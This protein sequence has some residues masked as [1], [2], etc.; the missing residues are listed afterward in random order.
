VAIELNIAES[1][2]VELKSLRTGRKERPLLQ[3]IPAAP[4]R[5]AD[6][7]VASGKMARRAQRRV[8]EHFSAPAILAFR[9]NAASGTGP[10]LRRPA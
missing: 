10:T 6:Q 1:I 3:P 4:R 5:T 8:K 2:T 9:Q 7:D